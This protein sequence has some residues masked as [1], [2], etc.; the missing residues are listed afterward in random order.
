MSQANAVT[1]ELVGLAKRTLE[2]F[3]ADP[4]LKAALITGS[5]A[6]GHADLNSD[7]DLMLYLGQAASA[8][9]FE[10]QGQKAK[11]SG[12]GVYGGTPEEGFG[13]FRYVDGVKVDLGFNLV[14]KTEQIFDKVLVEHDVSDLN[15]Q[16]VIRGI[17]TGQ[18]LYGEEVI[19]AWIERS[20]RYPDGLQEAMICAHY[21]LTP[22]WILD[23]M[24]VER[25]DP[26]LVYEHLFMDQKKLLSTLYALNREYHPNKFKS[27]NKFVKP[28][29]IKPKNVVERFDALYKLPAKEAVDELERLQDETLT[30]IET[31]MPTFDTSEARKWLEM[32]LS[33]R[34]QAI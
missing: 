14:E 19:K 33:K 6:Q 20:D 10:T 27:L 23:K 2:E 22:R 5:V 8:E 1:Q 18:T 26:F 13:V 12:G 16:L 29:K 9:F 7:I 30:L 28:L 25:D 21:R 34:D 17:R 4:N 11:E 31:H 3:T 15:L 32:K 24:G